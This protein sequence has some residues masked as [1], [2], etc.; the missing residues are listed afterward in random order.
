MESQKCLPSMRW[1]SFEGWDYDGMKE[2]L[3]KALEAIN[4]PA[5]IRHAE[6]VKGQNVFMS[7]PFSAGQYWICFEMVTADHTI[8]IA[9]FRLPRR[10]ASSATVSVEDEAYAMICE[11]ETMKFVGLKLPSIPIPAVYA[12]ALPRSELA[13]AAGAAYML[14]EGFHGNTLQ[15]VGG[16][17]CNLEVR[18]QEHN[19]S[20]WTW[21]QGQLA[22]ITSPKIGSIY[23]ISDRGE[24]MAGRLVDYVSM[25]LAETGPFSTARAYFTAVADTAVHRSS[26]DAQAGAKAFRDIVLRTDLFGNL[27]TKERFPLS[28]MDLGPQNVLVDSDFNFVAIIDWEFAQFA[29]WQTYHYPMPFPLLGLDTD[30]IL[31]DPGHLAFKNVLP[32]SISQALYCKGFKQPS[33]QDI[34]LLLAPWPVTRRRRQPSS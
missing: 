28:H 23:S 25:G 32:Q 24:P 19:M 13:T 29:P 17:L 4:K 1:T 8:I 18:T 30:D 9:R 15:D 12:C 14:L 3:Q 7:T 20:Q 31:K 5:L 26:Q 33:F 34:R 16:N 21:M 10:A 27:R 22:T 2:R 6:R 11:V